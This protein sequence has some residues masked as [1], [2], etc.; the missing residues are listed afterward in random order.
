MFA[1]W[2]DYRDEFRWCT[3]PGERHAKAACLSFL[4]GHT[5]SHRW[6]YTPKLN[7]GCTEF[8]DTVNERDR[9]DLRWLIERMPYWDW[10]LRNPRGPTLP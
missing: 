5:E 2:N 7:Q 4:D 10:P 9:E 3:T 6:L 1:P 8:R